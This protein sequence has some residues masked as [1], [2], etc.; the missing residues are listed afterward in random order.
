MQLGAPTVFIVDDD[1]SVRKALVRLVIS[2]GLRA[3][4][5]ASAAEFLA[6]SPGG[7]HGCL[8]LDVKMPRTTGPELQRQLAENGIDLPVI[9]VSAHVDVPLT[10]RAMKDG[11]FEVLTKP[12]QDDVLLEAV[13]QA[14]A[15]DDQRHRDRAEFEE[16]RQRFETLTPKQREVMAL[17]VTGMLNKQV[18]ARLGT[19]EKTV[20]VHRAQVVVKMRASS[21]PDL[22]RMADRL[23]L[24]AGNAL[25]PTT[26]PDIDEGVPKVQ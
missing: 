15:R 13:R 5:F 2:A 3:E 11:A 8:L 26:G 18:A 25:S 4:A 1:A 21:L 22:V 24:P 12:F 20:K 10:V 6:R 16:L 17:V 9:F 14:I 19:S 23:G 7:E